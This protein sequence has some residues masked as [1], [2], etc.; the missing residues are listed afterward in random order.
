MRTLGNI[1]RL[2][3]RQSPV[4]LGK[5][6]AWRAR[7]QWM[8]RRFSA[9]LLKSP[10]PVRLCNASYYEPDPSA[11]SEKT[12]GCILKFADAVREGKFPLLS[13]GTL[14][15]SRTPP[16]NRD[17]VSGLEWPLSPS[18]AIEI[19]RHDGSD[20]KAPW[21][22]SR[23][24]FLPILGKAYLLS[25]RECYREAAIELL[26][27]WIDRNPV[28]VGVNWTVAMEAALRAISI[29]LLLNLLWPLRPDE[30]RW[31]ERL[32]T[33]LWHHLLYIEANLEFSHIVRGNHYLSDIVGLFCL[34]QFLEGP[35]M[36][37]R[38]RAYWQ[39]IEHEIQR[40]VYD[41]GGD[42]EASTGYHVV[43]TQLFT[44]AFLLRRTMRPSASA[45]FEERLKRMYRWLAVLADS[46]GR[47]PLVGDCDDARVELLQ[48][49]LEQM[50]YVPV[51][52][53]H[54]LTVSNMLGLGGCLFGEMFG[55]RTDDA[56]WYGLKPPRPATPRL[57][58]R[59]FTV[60]RVTVLPQSGIAV[61]RQ[62]AA[63]VFLL[64]IPNGIGG[65]GS[66]THNDKLS[67]IVR[68]DGEELLC[69][70]GTGNYTR[71]LRWRNRHRST[72]AHNTVIIDNRE[73]NTIPSKKS[74]VFTLGD[75][76]RVTPLRCSSDGGFHQIEASHC[77][78]KRF[79]V[80]HKRILEVNGKNELLIEDHFL[81][82][83]EHHIEASFHL[84][85]QWRAS[86]IEHQGSKILCS[87]AG[88]RP[89]RL[90]FCSAGA[91]EADHLNSEVSVLYGV[92]IPAELIRVKGRLSLP[93]VLSTSL[94]W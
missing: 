30:S 5:E 70:S 64:A 2:A 26:L 16:W 74:G 11:V 87:I 40:Q 39:R 43:V 12:R 57:D 23:L 27:D 49:D 32:T 90:E 25:H 65:K 7:K 78:Y 44:T 37:P 33:S 77:G 20:V 34:S 73:Q 36:E 14:D 21:E 13:Y 53:R 17:F 85:P 56:I 55:G 66:H 22:L 4:T 79:G 46:H 82:A 92:S 18:H 3:I 29:T 84:A 71:E 1:L 45:R 42:Y 63:E 91:I 68:I 69:D 8:Q 35:G 31:L 28:A 47:L 93:S 67:V 89:V 24:Q 38:S 60:P 54:S 6:V 76:A 52:Q 94:R 75:E 9:R 81:G 10:C 61:L 15:L 88:P 72:R 58:K 48:D 19:V 83:G 62:G 59:D 80:V 41:D 86:C 51:S 50:L